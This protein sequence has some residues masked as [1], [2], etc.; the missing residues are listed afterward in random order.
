MK[1]KQFLKDGLRSKII[2][3]IISIVMVILC[4][5]IY[6]LKTKTL[7]A[8]CNDSLLCESTL[9]YGIVLP[10]YNSLIYLIIS[11]AIMIFFSFHFLK[12][13]MKIIIPYFIVALLLVI[14]TPALCEG[15]ICWDRT[16][17][18]SG[19]A[20]LFLILTVLIVISKSIYIWSVSRKERKT[21][22]P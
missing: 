5:A 18:A 16:L 11:I 2:L 4:C 20:K 14:S 15:M 13:W 3:L 21:L 8:P 9:F 17:V 1:I 10:L 22:T 7:L 12:I 6:F 19:L